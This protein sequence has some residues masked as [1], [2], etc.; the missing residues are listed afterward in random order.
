MHHVVTIKPLANFSLG[1]FYQALSLLSCILQAGYGCTVIIFTA[2]TPNTGWDKRAVRHQSALLPQHSHPVGLLA[3]SG[4]C[5]LLNG[6]MLDIAELWS[7][8]SLLLL[9]L[10]ISGLCFSESLLNSFLCYKPLLSGI[11]SAILLCSGFVFTL[12]CRLS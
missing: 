4:L 6:L 8:S 2:N 11:S 1:I 9:C 5:I 12:S 7:S 10:V 3:T